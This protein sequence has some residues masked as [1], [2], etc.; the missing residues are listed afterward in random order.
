MRI[1]PHQ[2]II[3]NF[4]IG[5]LNS[6]LLLKHGA[7]IVKS[8]KKTYL[9]LIPQHIAVNFVSFITDNEEVSISLAEQALVLNCTCALPKNKL[10]AHQVQALY[11]IKDRLQIKIY[12]D[13]IL[14][15]DQIKKVAKDYG[16]ENESN[17]E[18]FFELEYNAREVGIKLTVK[19]L[20][21]VNAATKLYI[22][23]QVLPES[24]KFTLPLD[25]NDLGSKLIVVFSE[26]RFYKLFTISLFEALT[27]NDG[28]IK[29][30]LTQVNPLDLIWKLEQTDELKFFGGIAKFQNNYEADRKEND[31]EALRVLVKN[32]LDIKFFMHDPKVSDKI[33]KGSVKPFQLEFLK[34]D[35]R[36]NVDL[37]GSLYE[38]SGVVVLNDKRYSLKM[39]QLVFDYFI[40]I[41]DTLYLIDNIDFIKV[42]SFF[43]KHNDTIII[44]PSKFDDFQRDIL[45]KLENRVQ[46]TYSYMRPATQQQIE[47]GDLDQQVQKIIYLSASGNYI[48]ITPVIK[49]TSVEVP[50]LSRKQ[51][52]NSDKHGN[53]FTLQRNEELEIDF[54]AHILKQHPHFQDQLQNESFYLHKQRFLDEDWFLNAFEEW[55]EKDII[56]LGFNE[57]AKNNIN[58][59]KAKVT[60]HVS[61]GINWFN[62]SL[63]VQFGRQKVMLKHLHKSI[64]DK[65]RFVQLDDGTLGV[66]PKEWIEKFNNYFKTGVVFEEQLRTPTI[67]YSAIEKYYDNEALSKEAK[68]SIKK[69]RSALSTFERIEN[70]EVSQAFRGVLRPYQ[71]QGLNWLNFLD[72]FNFGG[73]LADDMG[74]GKTIQ[75]IAFILSQRE[76]HK[77]NVNLIVVPTSLIFNWQ[78]EVARFAP[79]IKIHTLHG[80]N[81]VKFTNAFNN[82][83]IVLTTYG[84]LLSDINF[85]KDYHFNYIF[86][87]ESQ[88]IKNPESQRYKAV[89]MLQSK[90]KIVLTGTPFENNT[91]DIYGQMSFACPGLLGSKQYFNEQ[92]AIPIDQFK[93]SKNAI[94]LQQKIH[95]FLLRRTKQQVATELPAKT[96][97]IIYCEMNPK[98]RKIYDTYEQE[99]RS[100]IAATHDEELPKSSM[101]VLK[102]LTKLR[103]LCNSPALVS[104]VDYAGETAAKIEVIV[105]AVENKSAEHKILIFSQFVTMLDL[106]KNELDAKNI[107]Y[108]Y[109]TGNTKNRSAKVKS[110]Q[111]NESVRVFLVSLKAGGT[112]LNLTEADYVYLVDPWWNPAAENQ[113]IDR[114]YRIG[115]KK[116]V[117]AVR[118]ICPH[119]IEERIMQ[120]QKLKRELEGELIKTDTAILKS[121]NKKDLLALFS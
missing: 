43:K 85:L 105:E 35:L 57:L 108:E 93:D 69:Y 113:A 96:E 40:R 74:L 1:H 59:Y 5:E 3:Q 115:Q 118:L 72:E 121:L 100:Y 117:V 83:E 44:H 25:T 50:V 104:E 86:L 58:P 8:D 17:L 56:I 30:L 82:Y 52:Y 4:V 42:I 46:I 27:G 34:I 88:A 2:Y 81:R 60:V 28:K 109:L 54:T 98:Q 101:Y 21:A 94:E 33:T 112:G 65:S 66:L 16:F 103:Q 77:H 14:R 13:P 11:N 45:S 78:E 18:D 87:D 119:T 102:S 49:Y 20:Y 9:E 39:L 37:K 91:M 48:L 15:Q 55:R 63:Q 29:N 73:C 10:C 26:N 53:V 79:S 12:F 120:M 70:T 7:D 80:T 75:I 32:P 68:A 62:T 22:N 19:E 90:N 36:L 97:M 61:S 84:M 106:I 89:R 116:N 38:L 111:N 67:N 114:C 51:I 31:L 64:R 95:P 110:F 76:K 47:E 6:L 41:S 92:Y 24:N 71:K 99:V 107:N 23:E